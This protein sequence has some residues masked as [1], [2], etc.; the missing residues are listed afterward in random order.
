[1]NKRMISRLAFLVALSCG[2]FVG[3]GSGGGLLAQAHKEAVGYNALVAAVGSGLEDGSG[4]QVAMVEVPE[5]SA[6]RP[7]MANAEFLGK[8]FNDG[9]G[10]NNGNSGHATDVGRFYFG[11]NSSL[12]AG[13]DL[14]SGYNVNDW[15][16]SRLAPGGAGT[17]LAESYR[18][19]SHAYR[20]DGDNT[21]AAENLLMR[22]DHYVNQNGTTVVVGTSNSNSSIIPNLFTHGYNVIAVGRSSGLHG[23]GSTTIYGAGRTRPD[24][25]AP[26]SFTSWSTGLV[27]SAAALLHD[28]ADN[29][30]GD[31]MDARRPEVIKSILM[32]GAS[33]EPF[34]SWDRTNTRPID[35]R[36][37]AGQLNIFNSYFIMDG[38][39]TNGSLGVPT[40]AI[41]LRGWDYEASLSDSAIQS[42]RLEIGPGGVSDLSVMLN[43]NMQIIDTDPSDSVFAPATQLANLGL[44]LWDDNETLIDW[45][46]SSVDNVEHLYLEFLATGSYT[47]RVENH[48]D[49]ASSFALSWRMTAVPEPGSGGVLLFLCLGLVARRTPRMGRPVKI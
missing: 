9:S 23:H 21:A 5:G 32:S 39:Q 13:I 12:T 29:M 42:Y 16:G 43:W 46:N 18:V 25:V 47:L 45:S 33:K 30:G 22:M 19:S 2:L 34:A 17:P 27:S 37:G 4:I 7:N 11:N 8:T 35:E 48:S 10:T 40:E 14:F 24:L 41:G 20:G 26:L 36:F 28:K 31:A 15:L 38:G 49:F 44:S 6:Y 3:L 1:M